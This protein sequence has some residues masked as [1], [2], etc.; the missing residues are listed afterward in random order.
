MSCT[1]DYLHKHV[2]LLVPTLTYGNEEWIVTETS[3]SHMQ[4]AESFLC[5][6]VKR[7]R[8]SK[9]SIFKEDLVVKLLV[10]HIK[11]SL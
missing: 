10:F 4:A 9:I 3:R 2:D 8:E 7:L 11:R 5:R 1:T 6:V